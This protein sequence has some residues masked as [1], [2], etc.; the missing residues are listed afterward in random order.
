MAV[1]TEDLIKEFQDSEFTADKKYKGKT[2]KIT[3]GVV[4]SIDAQI[5]DDDKY[6]V[7][8]NS[9]REFEILSVNCRS[10]ADK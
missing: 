5:F 9:G 1:S 4:S 7:S 2:L 10:V 3:G 8:F 6:D